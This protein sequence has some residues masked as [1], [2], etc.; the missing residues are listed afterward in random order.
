MMVRNLIKEDSNYSDII[1]LKNG[2]F[3][4]FENIFKKYSERIF[5]YANRFLRNEEESKDIVQEVFL[6]IWKYRESI[7]ENL[8][9]EA[10]LF[11]ITKNTIFNI[12]KKKQHEIAYANFVQYYLKYEFGELESSII[13]KD[14]ERHTLAIIEQLPPQQK[15]VFNLSRFKG[16]SHREIAEQLSLSE[17]TVEVHIRLALQFIK[18]T[19][20]SIEPGLL[21]PDKN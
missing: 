21:N 18:K 11:T 13:Y 15:K 12:H 3:S 9:F 6:K 16:F 19:F 7:N 4:A 2:S 8:I 17:R 14:L 20:E 10:F 5:L 1:A